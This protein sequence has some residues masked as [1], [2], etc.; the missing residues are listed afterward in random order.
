MSLHG[1]DARPIAKGRLGKPVEFRFKA[2]VLDNA[3][4]AFAFS[5]IDQN[6][7]FAIGQFQNFTTANFISPDVSGLT[8]PKWPRAPLLY[9]GRG[10][11]PD[12]RAATGPT[13]S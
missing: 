9:E 13:E 11:G 2:Q 7:Q 10:D 4:Y 3:D 5:Q 8:N 1:P 6:N 12:S